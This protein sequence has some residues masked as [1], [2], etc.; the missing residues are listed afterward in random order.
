M[1]EKMY[2]SATW[3]RLMSIRPSARINP[4]QAPINFKSELLPTPAAASL[5]PANHEETMGKLMARLDQLQAKVNS[6]SEP[7]ADD[8]TFRSVFSTKPLGASANLL[9]R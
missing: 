2:L 7:S 6:Q 9:S 3:Q 8:A 4:T 5:A 1:W